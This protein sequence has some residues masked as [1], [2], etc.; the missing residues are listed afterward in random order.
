MFLPDLSKLTTAVA[1]G[2]GEGWAYQRPEM[3]WTGLGWERGEKVSGLLSGFHTDSLCS[4][5]DIECNH[6]SA[7]ALKFEGA[8]DQ[9]VMDWV[10]DS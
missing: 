1:V 6:I 5:N 3:S 7:V 9:N 8:A 10:V 4:Y 2:G